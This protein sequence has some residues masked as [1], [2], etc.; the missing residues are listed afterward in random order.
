MRLNKLIAIK[1]KGSVLNEF[2]EPSFTE[3]A[4]FLSVW[5]RKNIMSV[6]E[7]WTTNGDHSTQAASFRIHSRD[8]IT[9]DMVI[10]FEGYRYDI[11]GVKQ[12]GTRS[13]FIDILATRTE[14]ISSSS[15]PLYLQPGGDN[16]RQPD[17]TSFYLI[18]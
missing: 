13:Q 2:G 17:G 7:K 4:D 11:T 12:V 14:L 1:T 5:C 16:Y 15:L 6:Y 8:G 9:S 10:E 18:P 3:Y